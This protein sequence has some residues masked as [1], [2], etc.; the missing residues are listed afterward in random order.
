MER[1]LENPVWMVPLKV[2]NQPFNAAMNKA[3]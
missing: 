2:P 3:Q 1:M